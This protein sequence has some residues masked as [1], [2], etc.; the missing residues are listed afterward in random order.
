[1]NPPDVLISADRIHERVG[2][3]A[4][5]LNQ[6]YAGRKLTIVG[7]L[8]GSLLFLADLMRRLDMPLRIALIQALS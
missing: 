7:V 3:L 6:D 4:R 5:Q 8:T 1:M 2:E